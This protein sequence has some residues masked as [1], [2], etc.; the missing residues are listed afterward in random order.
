MNGYII[1][2]GRVLSYEEALKIAGEHRKKKK[3]EEDEKNTPS[4]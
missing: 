2:E 1:I 3:D 4:P